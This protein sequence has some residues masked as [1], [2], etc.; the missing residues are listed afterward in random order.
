MH[1]EA[2]N[3]HAFSTNTMPSGCPAF[4]ASLGGPETP[5]MEIHAGLPQLSES[6]EQV[7]YNLHLLSTF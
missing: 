3:V 6:L 7:V 4:E 2:V 5:E 1:S